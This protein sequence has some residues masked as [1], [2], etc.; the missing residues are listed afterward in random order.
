[1]THAIQE[2]AALQ[3]TP[4]V[5][6]TAKYVVVDIHS[7]VNLVEPAPGRPAADAEAAVA[8]AP[9]TQVVAALDRPA[10]ESQRLSTTLRV[11]VDQPT[12]VGG[13]TFASS[14]PGGANLYLFVTAHVQELRDDEGAEVKADDPKQPAD[15]ADSAAGTPQP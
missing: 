7:R 14:G 6:R 1:V 13:M 4:I 2:G 3:V 15:A 9:V 5:T 12:L 10:L 8:N 11:P